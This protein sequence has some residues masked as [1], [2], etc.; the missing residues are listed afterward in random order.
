MS[1]KPTHVAQAEAE[2]G[3][4]QYG[5]WLKQKHVD[6]AEKRWVKRSF[7]VR[8]DNDWYQCGGCRWFAAYGGDFGVCCCEE[9]ELDGCITFEHGGCRMHSVRL[10]HEKD[11]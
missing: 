4:W 1:K 9:S 3:G 2:P 5:P 6:A 10:E 7:R 8:G 11:G